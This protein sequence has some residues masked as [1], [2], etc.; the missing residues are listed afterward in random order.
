MTV[1]FIQVGRADSEIKIGVTSNFFVR[2]AQL[3]NKHRHTVW[4]LAVIDGDWRTEGEMHQKF[5]HLCT[6]GEWFV[7]G[8]ELVAFIKALPCPSEALIPLGLAENS[9]AIRYHAALQ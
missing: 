4:I 2:M 5:E 6:G 1:Y 9:A 8:P 7:P 3:R